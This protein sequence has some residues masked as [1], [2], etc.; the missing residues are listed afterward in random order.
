MPT[1][2]ET[3]AAVALAGLTA[4]LSLA[5]LGSAPAPSDFRLVGYGCEGTA[6][7]IYRDEEDQFPDG[8]CAVI[9]ATH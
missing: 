2:L 8:G 1:P 5:I 7:P 4:A 9:E 6:G 3:L